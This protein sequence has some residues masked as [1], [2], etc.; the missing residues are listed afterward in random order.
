MERNTGIAESPLHQHSQESA[1]RNERFVGECLKKIRAARDAEEGLRQLLCFLG[2]RLACDRVY[3][4]EEMNQQ[5]IRNTYEW[6]RP[7]VSSGI[8]ELP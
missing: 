7:G 1:A 5:H 6:C 8:E 3:M 2:E 4:F